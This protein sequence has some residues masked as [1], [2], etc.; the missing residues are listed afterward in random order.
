MVKWLSYFPF[1]IDVKDKKCTIFGGGLVAL[2]KVEALLDF[3]AKI[4]LISPKLHDDFSK[5]NKKIDI[6]IDS[7]KQKYLNGS[8]FVIAATNNEQV[9][10]EIFY[11]CEKNKIL[12]NVVDDIEKCVFIFPSYIKIDDISIGITSSGKSPS[13]SKQIKKDIENIIPNYYSNVISLLGKYRDTIK[14]RIVQDSLRMKTM[15]KIV[16]KALE[17]KEEFNKNHIEA[18]I[19]E[20]LKKDIKN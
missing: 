6:V 2:R 17:E 13:M 18:I 15:K 8:F 5:Y 12:I 7:Y 9:N 16:E 14:N 19:E 10:K 1:F 3:G 11:E 4:K 20:F